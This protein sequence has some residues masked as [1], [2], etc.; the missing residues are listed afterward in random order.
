MFLRGFPRRLLGVYRLCWP[1]AQGPVTSD[2]KITTALVNQKY[3]KLDD[4]CGTKILLLH[5]EL[6]M[7][8]SSVAGAIVHSS[9]VIK[10]STNKRQLRF[11]LC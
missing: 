1:A 9:Y 7:P 10:I 8:V 6:Q 5:L 2:F 11:V 4:I 3:M